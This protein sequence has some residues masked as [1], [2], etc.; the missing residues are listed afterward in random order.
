MTQH[1]MT[2]SRIQAVVLFLALAVCSPLM[3]MGGYSSDQIGQG[4]I[5]KIDYQH[6]TITVNGETY[7][8]SPTA[9]YSG[10]G[11]FSVLGVGMSIRYTLGNEI[12][13][14]TDPDASPSNII[15]QQAVNVPQM[16]VA[17]TWLPG[18]VK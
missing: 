14:D 12:S 5:R 17:I 6:H 15:S 8:V 11:G 1:T 4:Q 10:I 18:G 2:H 13:K 16:I 9:K 7:A 3:A